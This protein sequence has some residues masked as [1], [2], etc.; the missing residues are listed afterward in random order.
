MSSKKKKKI[1]VVFWFTLFL[2]SLTTDAFLSLRGYGLCHNKSRLTEKIQDM[3][4]SD[5]ATLEIL[6]TVYIVQVFKH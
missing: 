1:E 2:F 3:Q 5:S 4:S 6:K